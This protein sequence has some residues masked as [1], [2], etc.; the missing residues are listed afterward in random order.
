MRY[1]LVC[2]SRKWPMADKPIVEREL[3]RLVRDTRDDDVR[4]LHGGAKGA[5]LIGKAVAQE[6]GLRV[7]AMDADWRTHDPAWCRC[8]AKQKAERDYCAMAGH[9]RNCQMLDLLVERRAD[10]YPVEVMAFVTPSLEASSG[11]KNMVTIARASLLDVWVV[12]PW[13]SYPA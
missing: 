1:V 3:A 2:G 10:G 4:V 9:K 11:T 13:R 6:M 5:D 7:K 12:E 8:N